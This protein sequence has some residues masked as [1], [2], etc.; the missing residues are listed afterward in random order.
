VEYLHIGDSFLDGCS[1][2]RE[3]L[4]LKFVFL[5]EI[6]EVSKFLCSALLTGGLEFVDKVSGIDPEQSY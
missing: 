3:R 2:R 1:E 6:P 4:L 5:A